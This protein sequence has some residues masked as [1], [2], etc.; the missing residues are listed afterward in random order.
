M[1]VLHRHA[2]SWDVSLLC[3]VLLTI[4]TGRVKT[5]ADRVYFGKYKA[6]FSDIPHH[7]HSFELI[8]SRECMCPSGSARVH[9]AKRPCPFGGTPVSSSLVRTDLRVG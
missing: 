7:I 2:C 6:V 3:E 8:H 4:G 1:W 5:V 9:S